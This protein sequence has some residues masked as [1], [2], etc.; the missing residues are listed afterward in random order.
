MSSQLLT[1]LVAE[2]ATSSDELIWAIMNRE[3]S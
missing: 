2:Q 1:D 3:E